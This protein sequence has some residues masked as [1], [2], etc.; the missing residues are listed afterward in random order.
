MLTCVS[1]YWRVKNKYGGEQRYKKWFENTLRIN[2]PYVFFANKE[3]IELIKGF[4]RE[5]PTH[6]IEMDIDEFYMNK[7]KGMIKTQWEHCPSVEI[8]LI[9]NEKIFLMQKAKDL[10]P[11]NS[12]F[13]MW[14][15]AGITPYRDVYPPTTPFPNIDK[16][17]ALPKDRFIYSESNPYKEAAVDKNKYYHHIS[18]TYLLHKDFIDAFA[19]VYKRYLAELLPYDNIWTEQV[20]LTHM[21]KD[22]PT[23]FYKLCVGY[24]QTVIE[25]R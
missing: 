6:Y 1:G 12:E 9:W 16:L 21:F 7:Y 14:V 23:L 20:L 15:D 17:M 3:G 11:F 13:F 18:G 25:L 24:G 19:E 8:N 5:L 22:D 4:R 2:C 10:N